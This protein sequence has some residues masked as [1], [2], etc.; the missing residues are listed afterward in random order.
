MKR[1]TGLIGAVLIALGAL[2]FLVPKTPVCKNEDYRKYLKTT[3]IEANKAKNN[4]L[5][6]LWSNKL[7]DNPTNFTYQKTLAKL[8]AQQ[9]KITGNINALLKSDSLF[10]QINTKAPNQAEVLQSL[11]TNAIC[12]HAFCDAEAYIQ[13]ALEL[14]ENSS[15]SSLILA[16]L[17]MKRDASWRV[18]LMVKNIASKQNFDF[19]IHQV[20]DC[21]T[22]AD[23]ETTIETMEM[24]LTK[25]KR[26][27]N[28]NLVNWS[29]SKLGEMYSHDGRIEQSYQSYLEALQYQPHNL[30]A[31]KGIAWIAYSHDQSPKEAK[32]I[33]QFLKYVHHSPEYELL[34]AELAEFENRE[35]EMNQHYAAF[36]ALVADERYGNM[37]NSYLCLL[38]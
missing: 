13:Q 17:A 7:K 6:T 24:T 15:V 21:E 25:A 19:F 35:K 37:Y 26:S 10:Q 2:Y 1:T 32:R 31:L 29:L 30:Q 8:Y 14:G 12:R 33:I 20:K 11:A 5:I 4:D 28:L 34:L 16:D 27:N 3:F 9:F 38:P 18:E 23:W 36:K 22:P